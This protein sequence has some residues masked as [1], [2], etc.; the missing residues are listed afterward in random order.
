MSQI[1]KKTCSLIFVENTSKIK[2]PSFL[3]QI[4]TANSEADQ[5]SR[6]CAPDTIFMQISFCAHCIFERQ[7]KAA[8]QP[9]YAH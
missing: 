7:Q 5:S 2:K 6:G 9:T 3:L 1:D 8:G 4:R